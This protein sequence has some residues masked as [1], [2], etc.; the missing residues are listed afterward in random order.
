MLPLRRLAAFSSALL[1]AVVFSAGQA[2]AQSPEAVA[3]RLQERYRH[4][5]ALRAEF[6][7]TLGGQRLRGT[8]TVRGDAFRIEMDDQV[9]V[10]DGE[11][12][13]SYSRPDNQVVVQRYD[14]AEAGGFSVGQL[15][16]DWTS[17]FRVTG[18]T[19]A[20]MNGV[21]H[22]VLALR[23]REAG[24][25]VRDATLYVRSA[26]AVPTMVRVHDVNGQT[27]AFDLG[28]VQ[29]NP[30]LPSGTFSFRTPSGAEVVDLR[31]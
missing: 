25:P 2:A 11:T 4:V 12:L 30:R 15:F 3:R 29:L 13:W 6:V 14:P 21:R 8:M 27:L 28:N 26:D 1:A 23:P 18:A 9:L 31:S 10:S 22:D 24:S 17:L 19:Q 16:T 20:T 7:Q 5:G